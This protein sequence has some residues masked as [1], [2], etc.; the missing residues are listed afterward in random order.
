MSILL[1]LLQA[2]GHKLVLVDDLPHAHGP[3]Q[4]AR[5]S[6]LLTQ[7]AAT[8][9]NPVI[10]TLTE[11]PFSGGA[12]SSGGSPYGSGARSGSGAT[13]TSWQAVRRVPSAPETS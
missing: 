7:L 10:V 12:P 9:R 3:E 2:P 1:L 13:A 4:R 5:L 8:A 11:A 6:Q